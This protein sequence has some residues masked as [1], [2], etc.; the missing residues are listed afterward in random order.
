MLETK[1]TVPPWKSKS[2]MS[3]YLD[4][5]IQTG[6]WCTHLHP[7]PPSSTHLHPAHFNLH[8]APSNST[9]LISASTQ[10][11]QHPQQYS[12]QNIARNWAISSI[13]AEKFKVIHFEWKL[14]NMISQG[15]WFLF[16]HEI[17][18]FLF[19]ISNPKFLLGK[20]WAKNVKIVRFVWKFSH[21]VF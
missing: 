11:L 7:P 2:V 8:P 13:Y 9:Q 3:W 14:A 12:N 5:D 6:K 4:I 1:T 16:Q 15:C 18:L 20:L 17:L 19:W 10:L 21:M